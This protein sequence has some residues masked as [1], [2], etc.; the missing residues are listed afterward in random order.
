MEVTTKSFAFCTKNNIPLYYVS[1]ADGT[2]VVK[3]RVEQISD[4]L[5]AEYHDCIFLFQLFNDAVEKAVGYKKDPIDIDDQIMEELENMW[6][7][8]E[9]NY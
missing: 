5:K 4:N 8:M 3:V 2:N 9:R 1:A 7:Y 6:K